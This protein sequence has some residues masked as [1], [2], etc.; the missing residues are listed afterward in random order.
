MDVQQAV[1][2]KKMKLTLFFSKKVSL[3]T[4]DETGMF[5]REVA[6]Y[7]KHA[8]KGIESSFVTYDKKIDPELLGKIPNIPLLYN[9]LHLPADS[10]HFL[11]P[12]LHAGHLAKTDII[13]T[14]QI[15]GSPAAV[16]AAHL[17][18]KPL[19]ARCGYMHSEFSAQKHGE[20]SRKTR[21]ILADEHRLF[22]YADAIIVT[23]EAMAK[24]IVSRLPE[25]EQKITVIPNYV[26]TD[27]FK[28]QDKQ[29]KYDL[30]FIGRFSEQKNLTSL[31]EAVTKL[32]CSLL[33]IGNGSNMQSL[34]ERYSSTRIEWLGNIPNTQLPDY[35]NQAKIFVLPSH[36]E[37][38]PKTLIEAMACGTAAVGADAPGIREVIIQ[39]ETGILTKNDP[40]S[41]GTTIQSLLEN[42]Q[43][44]DRLGRRARH[45]AV[46]HYS[47]K[48]I[49]EK[50]FVVLQKVIQHRSVPST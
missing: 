16:M 18:H 11:S 12:I 38:H 36:Y 49:A 47:L 20:E 34:K 32:G 24:S 13:K 9:R 10:Y 28:P 17:F 46:N 50:E 3:A 39:N 43:L 40:D 15:S 5:D 6:L 23:T 48:V 44:R 27:R 1:A 21:R 30:V 19:V 41:L 29:K 42:P 33:V 37:G 31:L 25:T 22:S 4:W 35:I 14:N 7:K 26:D 8:E 45:F 2:E